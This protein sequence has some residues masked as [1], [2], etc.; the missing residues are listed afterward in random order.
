MNNGEKTLAACEV[1]K[2]IELD[3]E[4][5]VG[6]VWPWSHNSWGNL[7]GIAFPASDTVRQRIIEGM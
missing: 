4:G 7:P 1:E 2:E 3:I 5:G 6:G